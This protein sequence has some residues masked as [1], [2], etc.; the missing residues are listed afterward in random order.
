MK[1]LVSIKDLFSNNKFSFIE[2]YLY[3]AF[4]GLLFSLGSNVG[5][6]NYE[7]MSI[8]ESL[9]EFRSLGP[10]IVLSI[11]IIILLQIFIKKKILDYNPIIIFFL[12]Y[13]LFQIIGFYLNNLK[14]FHLH[15]IVGSLSFISL[16]LIILNIDKNHLINIIKIYLVFIIFFIIFFISQNPSLSYG[17]GWI[18]YNNEKIVILNY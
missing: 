4:T 9:F 8:I 3:F 5:N 1:N 11:N 10:W 17:S 16:I 15:F 18:S 6:L 7:G 2:I 14:I 12:L 13:I